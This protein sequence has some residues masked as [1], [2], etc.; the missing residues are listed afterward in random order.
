VSRSPHTTVEDALG[1]ELGHDLGH[2]QRRAGVGVDGLRTTVCPRRSRG[3][4]FQT[5]IIIG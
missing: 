1:Q 3:A 4:H 2:Q 5:A